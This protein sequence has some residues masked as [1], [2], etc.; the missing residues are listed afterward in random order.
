MKMKNILLG[1]VLLS[2][3]A[4]VACNKENQTSTLKLRLTDAPVAADEV[5]IDLTGVQ[6]KFD[7]DTS[8]WVTMEAK[9]GIYNLLG[10]QNGVDT[11]IAQG[12]YPTGVVKEIRLVVGTNNTIVINGQTSP[13]TIPSGAESG[14]KIKVNKKLQATIET[15]VIDFDAALSIKQE[16]D[17]YKLRPVVKV[18]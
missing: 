8:K 13:L 3:V 1:T 16:N 6:V 18:K 7:K 4:F 2:A 12:D 9:T 11:L 14:L 17:G 5:N 15:V 10:L